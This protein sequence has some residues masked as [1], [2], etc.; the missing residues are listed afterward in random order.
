MICAVVALSQHASADELEGRT[1]TRIDELE[2]AIVGGLTDLIMGDGGA[3]GDI[4]TVTVVSSTERK[5]SVRIS[6]TGLNNRFVVVKA[7]DAEGLPQSG[8]TVSK[9]KV[10]SGLSSIDATIELA[11]GLA[12]GFTLDSPTLVV[13]AERN[14]GIE[15]RSALFAL[16][17]SWSVAVAAENVIVQS[18]L[19]PIGQANTLLAS[20]RAPPSTGVSPPPRTVK[21]LP[22]DVIS[23]DPS[24]LTLRPELR[25]S[26]RGVGTVAEPAA[27]AAAPGF[28]IDSSAMRRVAVAQPMLLSRPS[29]VSES[30]AE[31]ASVAQP[32]SSSSA[33]V[34]KTELAKTIDYAQLK[35]DN[36]ILVAQ[37]PTDRIR[38]YDFS[39]FEFAKPNQAAATEPASTQPTNM[40]ANSA[41]PVFDV[42]QTEPGISVDLAE[43]LGMERAIFPDQNP[44]SGIFY[45]IPRLYRIAYD[46]EIGGSQ[47]LA[48]RID[49]STLA[50]PG[51]TDSSVNV[52]MTLEA[53]LDGNG[54]AVAW[55]LVKAYAATRTDM[56]FTELR[57]L[58]IASVPA[59]DF[60]G[61]LAGAVDPEKIAVIAF[62]DF[63]EGLQVS[64]R[65]DPVRAEN[66]RRQLSDVSM[67]ITGRALFPLP[68]STV[69]A[70]REIPARVNLSDPAV[71]EAIEFNRAGE[72]RNVSPLPVRLKYLHALVLAADGGPRVYSWSLGDVTVP[73]KSRLALDM[74]DF[75]AGIDAIADRIWIDYRLDPA[76]GD[77]VTKVVEDVLRG[78]VWPDTG[79]I[80]VAALPSAF[81][82]GTAEIV[83]DVRSRFFKPTEREVT[84]APPL[85]LRAGAPAEKIEPLF[86]AD[87]V[88]PETGETWPLFEYR[89][90]VIREDGEQVDGEVWIP[91]N[92]LRVTPGSFQLKQSLGTSP[93]GSP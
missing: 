44:R 32:A 85:Y 68:S 12:E 49:Y 30:S 1:L 83:M 46:R 65:T 40:V 35:E 27:P 17:K 15:V 53:P 63:L 50:E 14:D 38:L 80:T 26:I 73:A 22:G 64:W 89:L 24:V 60:S 84:T 19:T 21:P 58:P 69:G 86:M 67:G 29:A 66:I 10:S 62:S 33:M 81:E 39:N 41:P 9:T 45:Y 7:G 36:Q 93:S 71:F 51:E 61:S 11:P 74:T 79:T 52:A 28:A 54:I 56:T 2:S 16:N 82:D 78:G 18:R 72:M 55:Q 37:L 92:S 3:G 59:F 75:P 31:T 43:V 4:G 47:G 87:Q 77:C 8:V 57:P 48:M 23:L 70:V 6:V 20:L 91:A 25:A 90:S 76:C 42:V 13:S 5:L 88:S 34:A